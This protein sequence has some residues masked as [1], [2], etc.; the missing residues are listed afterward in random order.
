MEKVGLLTRERIVNQVEEKIKDTQGYFF[1]G[2]N[3]INAFALNNLRNDLKGAGAQIFVA[4]NSLFKRALEAQGV[5]EVEDLLS[6]E[7]GAVFVFDKDVVGACKVLVDFSKENEAMALK[8]GVIQGD[9]ITSKDVMALAKLPP[10]EILLGI[11]VSTLAAP[12]SGFV[13]S[14]NQIIL[15]FVW[16][17]EEIKK[18]K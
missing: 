5:K 15:K 9:K 4:K 2:F 10:K 13:N 3:K 6:T 12:L 16:A 18:K 11:A 17:I 8:G 14:L 1:I 7:T